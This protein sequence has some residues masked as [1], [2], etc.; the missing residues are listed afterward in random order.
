MQKE[1]ID[2]LDNV[3]PVLIGSIYASFDQQGR[4]GIDGRIPDDVFQMPLNSI[5]PI[6]QIEQGFETV[7]R[8]WVRHGCIHVIRSVIILNTS[9]EN[10]KKK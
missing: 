1:S 7:F 6:L 2:V 8:K 5:D 4:G 9:L 3:G 10:R